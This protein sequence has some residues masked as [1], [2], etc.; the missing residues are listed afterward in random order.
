MAVSKP[1]D[2][3]CAGLETRTTAAL[4]S[5]DTKFARSKVWTGVSPDCDINHPGL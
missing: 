5:G 4:E 1:P 3:I 2:T